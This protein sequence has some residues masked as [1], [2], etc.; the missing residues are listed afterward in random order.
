MYSGRKVRTYDKISADINVKAAHE[1]IQFG[2]SQRDD[3]W[4]V[5]RVLHEDV[6]GAKLLG[7]LNEGSRHSGFVNDICHEG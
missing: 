3:V 5:C 4:K 7:G 6:D 1:L 2:S